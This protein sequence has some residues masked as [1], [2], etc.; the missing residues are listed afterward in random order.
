M[1]PAR[2]SRV[3]S[4]IRIVL[5]F[6]DAFNRHDIDGML[7]C[8][9]SDCVLETAR[10]AP[11]GISYSGRD[12]LAHFWQD[13]FR[14]SPQASIEVEE[15]FSTGFRCI[16]RWRYEWAAETGEIRHIRGVDIFQVKNGLICEIFS[17]V[18]SQ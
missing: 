2:M 14:E 3:E 6:K 8:V 7:H 5:E 4:A 13:L 16:L 10:P 11:D 15:A 17:Y 1:S 9:S 18:K 12:A